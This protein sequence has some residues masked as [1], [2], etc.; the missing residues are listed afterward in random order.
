[1]TKKKVIKLSLLNCWK[2]F[3][4]S[5]KEKEEKKDGKKK[6]EAAMIMNIISY[7]VTQHAIELGSTTFHLFIQRLFTLEVA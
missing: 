2:L 7:S 1:M 4:G 6:D 5:E 3:E